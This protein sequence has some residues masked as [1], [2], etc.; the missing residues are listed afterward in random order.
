MKQ[1]IQQTEKALIVLQWLKMGMHI[2]LPKHESSIYMD[3]KG[4]IR[5]EDGTAY[6]S[7]VNFFLR[8]CFKMDR[9]HLMLCIENN[10]VY[11]W[12]GVENLY[13]LFPKV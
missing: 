10:R 12:D 9:G 1:H 6:K 8:D 2:F 13:P 7:G 11:N 5:W 4:N 3:V